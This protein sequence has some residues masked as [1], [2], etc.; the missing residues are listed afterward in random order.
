[1][2]GVTHIFGSLMTIILTLIKSEAVLF[3]T[4]QSPIVQEI[5]FTYPVVVR[6]SEESYDKNALPH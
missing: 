6:A 4:L 2:H 3:H 5:L 1:M